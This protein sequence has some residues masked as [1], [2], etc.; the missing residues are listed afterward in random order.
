M[1]G[2][3]IYI[4]RNPPVAEDSAG[5]VSVVPAHRQICTCYCFS[6]STCVNM[7]KWRKRELLRGL[8][9]VVWQRLGVLACAESEA[10]KKRCV[11]CSEILQTLTQ[12]LHTYISCICLLVTVLFTLPCCALVVMSLPIKWGRNNSGWLPVYVQ[13]VPKFNHIFK[14]VIL[15][16]SLSWVT[17]HQKF[18]IRL[19]VKVFYMCTAFHVCV[20]VS[21]YSPQCKMTCL[22]E[23][24]AE[25]TLK[26]ELH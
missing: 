15:K 24:L 25:L 18:I 16:T 17:E 13:N 11:N 22:W 14:G 5:W 1:A 6:P 26:T 8:W 23:W 4:G 2:R 3:E 20:I 19:V 7:V 12:V 10:N 21:W 9:I